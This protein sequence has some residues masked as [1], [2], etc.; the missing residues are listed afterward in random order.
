MTALMNHITTHCNHLNQ[1]Y[2]NNIC[3]KKVKK[4]IDMYSAVHQ[5]KTDTVCY[6]TTAALVWLFSTKDLAPPFSGRWETGSKKY[7]NYEHCA[8]AFSTLGDDAEEGD[9]EDGL[10]HTVICINYGQTILDSHWYEKRTLTLL[11]NA[12]NTSLENIVNPK[13]TYGAYRYIPFDILP[14][15]EERLNT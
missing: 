6:I 15:I 14:G 8:V 3:S 5:G 13:G 11:N 10:E 1:Y 9:F 2:I 4:M 12:S 7:E